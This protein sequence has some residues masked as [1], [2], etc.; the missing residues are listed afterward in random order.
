MEGYIYLI[1]EKDNPNNFK[2]GMTKRKDINTRLKQLQT[3]N[4][5]ELYIKDSFKSKYPNKVEKLLHKR[6]HIE[7][8]LNEWFELDPKDVNS[9]QDICQNYETICESLKDNI[10]FNPSLKNELPY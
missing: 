9:F 4:P 8:K 1:C 7:H 5:S 2:I 6:F 10:F 3:G